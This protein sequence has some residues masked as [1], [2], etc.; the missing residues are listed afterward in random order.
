MWPLLFLPVYR[1]SIPYMKCLGSPEMFGIL[2]YFHLYI[3]RY[4]ANGKKY[5]TAEGSWEGLFVLGTKKR[6]FCLFAHI[7][8]SHEVMHGIFYFHYDG[9]HEILEHSRLGM[10]NLYNLWIF[11]KL[12][13]QLPD[14]C[15]CAIVRPK[16]LGTKGCWNFASFLWF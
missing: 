15:N 13:N 14:L 4:L 11:S 12:A 6:V 3:M 5:I 16:F 10:L 2:K 7:V 9:V 1:L 8:T